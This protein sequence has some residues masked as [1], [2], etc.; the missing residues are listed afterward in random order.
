MIEL[1]KLVGKEVLFQLKN[2]IGLSFAN[3][4][5]PIPLMTKIVKKKND[6]G[7]VE[8]KLEICMD[9][10]DADSKQMKAD[11]LLG[12]VV[13]TEHGIVV[14]LDDPVNTGCTIEV[15]VA[16]DAILYA[17]IVGEKKSVILTLS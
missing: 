5:R 2:E 4:G 9:P 3:G 12:K 16:D 8:N 10:R 1:S 6:D 7:N 15:H 17:S 13:E 11:Y 14:R